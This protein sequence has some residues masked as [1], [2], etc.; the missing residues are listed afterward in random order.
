MSPGS[1]PTPPGGYT[2]HIFTYGQP[3]PPPPPPL[4]PTLPIARLAPARP[5]C[6]LCCP[7]CR[8]CV[9][10]AGAQPAEHQPMFVVFVTPCFPS[11][12]CQSSPFSTP[13]P[14]SKMCKGCSLVLVGCWVCCSLGPGQDGVLN[15]DS[16]QMRDPNPNPN[17]AFC[18]LHLI[19][20]PSSADAP[21][22]LDLGDINLEPAPVGKRCES[23]LINFKYIS[24]AQVLRRQ[25]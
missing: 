22:V 14:Q 9:L 23:A 11:I 5:P 6:T 17:I 8:V 20:L 7:G 25:P 1:P 3:T 12:T 21:N 16:S 18:S 15:C 19:Y 10:T 4:S 2:G 24:P 13:H